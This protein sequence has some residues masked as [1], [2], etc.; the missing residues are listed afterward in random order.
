MVSS[1][2][3]ER[4]NLITKEKMVDHCEGK[5]IEKKSVNDDLESFFEDIQLGKELTKDDGQYVYS[6]F[7]PKLTEEELDLIERKDKDFMYTFYRQMTADVSKAD[8]EA[9]ESNSKFVRGHCQRETYTIK[10]RR[11]FQL[12][13]IDLNSCSLQ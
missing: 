6:Y 9:S 13:K 8:M 7:L 3:M 5:T 2:Y 12:S 11:I 1:L 10:N 4:W